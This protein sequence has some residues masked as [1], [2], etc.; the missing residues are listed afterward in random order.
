MVAGI[1][2]EGL[3]KDNSVITKEVDDTEYRAEVA[4]LNKV[5]SPEIYVLN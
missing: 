2:P 1:P 3:K 4:D 5:D